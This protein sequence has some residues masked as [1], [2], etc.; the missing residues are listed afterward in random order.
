[1][2]GPFLRTRLG[3]FFAIPLVCIFCTSA[4]PSSPPPP[5]THL[6]N[7]LPPSLPPSSLYIY[8]LPFFPRFPHSIV[9]QSHIPFPFS[10]VLCSPSRSPSLSPC[11]SPVPSRLGLRFRLRVGDLRR[12]GVESRTLSD[13]HTL[14]LHS[15]YVPTFCDACS[16]LLIGIMQQGLRRVGGGVN[17]FFRFYCCC[18]APQT[19]PH[20]REKS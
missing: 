4:P 1:M 11:P 17:F 18:S 3:F 7:P 12:F 9:A 8:F 16:Q 6:F 2:L 10:L 19:H 5:H 13:I 14:R 20:K 15:Y